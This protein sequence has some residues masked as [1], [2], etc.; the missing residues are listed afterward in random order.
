MSR[1]SS[2][3]ANRKL[4][5]AR[6]ACAEWKAE[7]KMIER[8]RRSIEEGGWDERIRSREASKTCGDVVGGFEE[9]CKGFEAKMREW[10]G[11]C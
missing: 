9:V 7:L 10:E 1:Q 11:V 4:R 3:L 2:I 6:E 5:M 8:C